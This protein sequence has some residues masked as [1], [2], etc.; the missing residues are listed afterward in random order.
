MSPLLSQSTNSFAVA[1]KANPDFAGTGTFDNDGDFRAD[2]ELTWT[3]ADCA[4]I[5]VP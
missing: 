1:M 4:S 5:T 2:G 3:S